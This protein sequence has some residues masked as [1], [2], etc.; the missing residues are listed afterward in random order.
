MPHHRVV[1][2]GIAHHLQLVTDGL[3]LCSIDDGLILVLIGNELRLLAHSVFH[4]L[5]L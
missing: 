3:G 4:L 5:D 2:R 1:I